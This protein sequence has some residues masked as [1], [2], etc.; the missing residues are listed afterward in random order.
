M[1]NSQDNLFTHPDMVVSLLFPNLETEAV[2]YKYMKSLAKEFVVKSKSPAEFTG[3]VNDELR[4]ETS[5]T[6][7]EALSHLRQRAV[8][9]FALDEE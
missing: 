2:S 9:V 4:R 5:R 1:V 8:E 6:R 3:L 7:R